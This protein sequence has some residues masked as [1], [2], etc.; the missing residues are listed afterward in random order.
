MGKYTGSIL[1]FTSVFIGASALAIFTG[2][3]LLTLIKIFLKDKV[4]SDIILILLIFAIFMLVLLLISRRQGYYINNGYYNPVLIFCVSAAI[5]A[6]IYTGVAFLT[7]FHLLFFPQV[8]YTLVIFI[9]ETAAG[10]N[11]ATTRYYTYMSITYFLTLIPLLA[12]LTLG[13]YSGCKKR[14][15]DRAKLTGKGK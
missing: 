4:S 3:F 8:Y 12:A 14:A 11:V 13:Y 5:S 15:S 10:Y 9:P 6:A 7:D 1:M 2:G